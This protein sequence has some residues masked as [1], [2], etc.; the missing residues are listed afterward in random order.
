MEEFERLEVELKSLFDQYI[1]RVRCLDALRAQ[2]VARVRSPNQHQFIV[3]QP[4][5][6]SISFLPE[7][8]L[9]SDENGMDDNDDDLRIPGE[10]RRLMHADGGNS[11]SIDEFTAMTEAGQMIRESRRVATGNRLRVRTA[12]NRGGGA[13]GNGERRFVGNM[14]GGSDM[15]SSLE[16][17]DDEESEDENDTGFGRAGLMNSDDD[18]DDDKVRVR[19]GEK[20]TARKI[21]DMSDEDF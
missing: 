9:D 16:T 13:A 14:M 18:E 19:A 20:P 12:A 21:T 5:D 6:T 7:G 15:D 4:S 11:E 10:R 2:L 3:A 8:I 1:V 17:D